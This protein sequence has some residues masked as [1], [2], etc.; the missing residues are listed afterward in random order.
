MKIF[1]FLKATSI[2]LWISIFGLISTFVGTI[3]YW[4]Y[5]FPTTGLNVF[6]FNITRPF[7]DVMSSILF[8]VFFTFFLNLFILS[9]MFLVGS[10]DFFRKNLLNPN[11][12][13][14]RYWTFIF[15]WVFKKL[16][17]SYLMRNYLFIKDSLESKDRIDFTY[18]N[19]NN[20][21]LPFSDEELIFNENKNQSYVVEPIEYVNEDEQIFRTNN[22]NTFF[23]NNQSN[24][25]TLESNYEDAFYQDDLVE[26]QS[27]NQNWR[28]QTFNTNQFENTNSFNTNTQQED[29]YSYLYAQPNPDAATQS[30]GTEYMD[31]FAKNQEYRN[32]YANNQNQNVSNKNTQFIWKHP[33]L[34]KAKNTNTNTIPKIHEIYKGFPPQG[35]QTNNF[36]PFVNP[37]TGQRISHPFYSD[38]RTKQMMIQKQLYTLEF[39]YKSGQISPSDYY[40]KRNQITNLK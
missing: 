19:N 31:T 39:M 3:L 35:L 15:P 8:I 13:N 2:F 28:T 32:Y 12:I 7:P 10:I 9:S 26:P 24:T 22:V 5:L 40:V 18:K 6:L 16:K 34:I 37:K 29:T 23:E 25:N 1:K 4:F 27:F 11:N 38:Q 36:N 14:F 33:N 17:R 30:F 21:D 20:S